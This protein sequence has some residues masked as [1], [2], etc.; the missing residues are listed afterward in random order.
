MIEINLVPVELRKKRKNKSLLRGL[1]IPRELMIGAGGGVVLFLLGLHLVLLLV[2]ITRLVH[3]KK[4]QKQWAQMSPLKEKV[5]S[6]ATEMRGLQDQLATLDEVTG[7]SNILWSRKL[8]I[9]SDTLP[10]GVWF[11][12]MGFNGDIFSVEGSAIS[13]QGEEMIS[14]HNFTSA[15]KKN[16]DFLDNF[17][18]LKLGSIQT[19]K[20]DK[21]EIADFLITTNLNE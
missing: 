3:Y 9:L 14:V 17:A 16:K 15:L 5:D 12:K 4:L 1:N 8:N 10:R 21:I 6:V 20:L 19:R 13:R 11:K 7:K 2:N 18:D